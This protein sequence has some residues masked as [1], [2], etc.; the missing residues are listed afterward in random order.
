MGHLVVRLP[1]SL[2]ACLVA[3][4]LPGKVQS[5][6]NGAPAELPTLRALYQGHLD[7]NGGRLGIESIQS[8]RIKGRMRLPQANQVEQSKGAGSVFTLYRKRPNRMRMVTEHPGLVTV[9]IYDGHQAYQHIE[10]SDGQIEVIDLD[11]GV[12]PEVRA[13]SQIGGVFYQYAARDD[14]FVVESLESVGEESAIRV[15]VL[16]AAGYAYD[17]IWLSAEHFQIVQQAIGEPQAKGGY[18]KRV[19]YDDFKS[20]HGVW[21]PHS[22]DYYQAGQASL[23]VEIDQVQ[24]N[25]GL[26]DSL[27]IIEEN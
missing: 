21:L 7:A 26:F 8:L 4:A 6:E 18:L 25:V 16:P 13:D 22:V 10:S 11:A 3:V 15:R 20:V 14:Y 2:L 19:R 9:L 27:F 5:G 23:R 24:A 12:L 1:W 17:Y